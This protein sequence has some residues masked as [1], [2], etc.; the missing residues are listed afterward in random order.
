MPFELI[1]WT[2][3]IYSETQ[4]SLSFAGR[5]S[6]KQFDP[7]YVCHRCFSVCKL[8]SLT[9]FCSLKRV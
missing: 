8:N 1:Q 2:L 3:C 6:P 7:T 5:E 4:A 9:L